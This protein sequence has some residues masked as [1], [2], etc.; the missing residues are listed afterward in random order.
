MAGDERSGGAQHVV[1][2]VG[3][4]VEIDAASSGGGERP[5]GVGRVDG[6]EPLVGQVSKAWRKSVTEE[7]EQAE[8]LVGVRGGIGGDHVGPVATVDFEDAV[9][10]VE[11]VAHGAG[12]HNGTDPD[13][14]VVQ[15]V[16]PGKTALLSEV[17]RGFAAVA[18]DGRGT[19][20]RMPSA[21]AHS[22][23]PQ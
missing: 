6:P 9:K 2:V 21:D 7:S 3:D 8:H 20:N 12:D 11:R 16:E 4:E 13:A 18:T 23:P 17:A 10:D 14:L 1:P 19:T 5:V 22:T 15:D